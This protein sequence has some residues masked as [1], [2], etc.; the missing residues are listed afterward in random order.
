MSS[1]IYNSRTVYNK[2]VTDTYAYDL[3]KNILSEVEVT[4]DK[5]ISLSIEN[6]LLTMFGERVFL[7]SFGSVL[8]YT[9]FD[10]ITES[11]AITIFESIMDSIEL[12]EGRIILDRQ[13]AKLDLFLDNNTM[14]LQIPYVIR[15]SGIVSNFKKKV[16]L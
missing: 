10:A 15:N 14:L 3:S 1:S 8:Q 2:S 7:Y 6:I 4:N 13:N 11:D 5:A 12:W 16:I 9:L